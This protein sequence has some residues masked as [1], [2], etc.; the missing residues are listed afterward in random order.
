M[1]DFEALKKQAALE[2]AKH[3]KDGM[4]LGLGTGSTARHF[5]DAVGQKIRDEMT[6]ICVPTSEETRRQAEALHIPLADLDEV[7]RLDLTID[8]ADEIDPQKR[9]IKGAGAAL[10]R[11]KIVAAASDKMLVIADQT[12]LVEKLGAFPL[13]IEV[14]RFSHRTSAAMIEAVI[15]DSGNQGAL[16]LRE[17][18]GQIVVTDGGHYLYDADLTE[19]QNIEDFARALNQIPGV[20]E[21]GLFI[22]LCAGAY[23]ATEEGIKEIS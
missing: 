10:L 23:L 19:I 6:L 3:I 15:A 20:V 21:H 13:P 18:E 14:D 12:K 16:R 7:G 22:G 17:K 4:K 8:G 11:E 2:A 9:L 1:M 5:V